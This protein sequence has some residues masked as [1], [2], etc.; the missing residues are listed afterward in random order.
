MHFRKFNISGFYLLKQYST[1]IYHDS[2]K[3]CP[4]FSRYIPQLFLLSLVPPSSPALKT[5]ESGR[6]WDNSVLRTHFIY[7]SIS[8]VPHLNLCFYWFKMLK[9]G[10]LYFSLIMKFCPCSSPSSFDFHEIY[11]K[12]AISTNFKKYMLMKWLGIYN[13]NNSDF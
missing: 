11:W 3:M 12:M 7:S 2:R 10:N 13:E 8:S 1:P 6:I 4:D 9:S 5:T